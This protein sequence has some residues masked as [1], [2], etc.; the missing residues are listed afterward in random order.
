[1]TTSQA[2]RGID[3]RVLGAG[4][5]LA[6]F[7]LTLATA[8]IHATLGGMLFTLNAIGYATFAVAMILPGPMG[9]IRW[10]VRLGLTGFTVVTIVAWYLFGAR[11]ELAYLDKGIEVVL[12]AF[13]AG[14]IWI[15]DGGPLGIVR[16]IQRLVARS[17]R[18]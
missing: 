15:L 1:M 6:V 16:R 13:L 2:L 18:F 12:V 10:L 11:F 7:T 17:C 3:H 9:R 5:G 8:A 14:E 4:L